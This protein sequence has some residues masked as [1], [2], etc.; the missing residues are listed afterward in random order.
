MGCW[1][2]CEIPVLNAV[3]YKLGAIHGTGHGYLTASPFFRLRMQ[4]GILCCASV[5]TTARAMRTGDEDVS[6]PSTNHMPSVTEPS[7]VASTSNLVFAGTLVVAATYKTTVGWA[8]SGWPSLHSGTFPST[9]AKWS[10]LAPIVSVQP[11]ASR[12]STPSKTSV[13]MSLKIRM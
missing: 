7:R 1:V 4:I 5:V 10:S 9:L 3:L 2:L 11:C 8:I 6:H 12:E 13:V